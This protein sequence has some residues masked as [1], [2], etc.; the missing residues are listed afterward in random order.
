LRS[1]QYCGIKGWMGRA[2]FRPNQDQGMSCAPNRGRR[3]CRAGHP[4][5]KL[6]PVFVA[7]R[8]K[9][10]RRDG[11]ST[12]RRTG[13]RY[14]GLRLL[15]RG[16]AQAEGGKGRCWP[17]PEACRTI[18]LV[19]GRP[20]RKL[21]TKSAPVSGRETRQAKARSSPL[22]PCGG[23]TFSSHP[24]CS[25]PTGNLAKITNRH[26]GTQDYNYKPRRREKKSRG[27]LLR[28]CS[29]GCRSRLCRRLCL[30]YGL[31]SRTA[32]CMVA[33]AGGYRYVFAPF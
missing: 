27:W 29:W 18:G 23:G 32:G 31:P 16:A 33:S 13:R 19:I 24:R 5:G 12:L 21:L 3:P 28:F 25:F 15:C 6:E 9:R 8:A 10:T 30:A 2:R 1:Y 26:D 20:R 11:R 7:S 22:A 14:E 17:P 4:E